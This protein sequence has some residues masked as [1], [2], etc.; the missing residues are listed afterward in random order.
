MRGNTGGVIEMPYFKSNFFACNYYTQ[1]NEFVQFLN[2]LAEI[3]NMIYNLSVISKGFF[4]I[5][6]HQV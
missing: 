4:S 2:Y 6:L 5:C 1:N 3:D